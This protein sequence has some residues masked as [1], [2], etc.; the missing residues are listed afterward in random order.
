MFTHSTS[1]KHTNTKTQSLSHTH[2]PLTTAAAAAAAIGPYA[3]RGMAEGYKHGV[4]VDRSHIRPQATIHSSVSAD[5]TSAQT[6]AIR[7]KSNWWKVQN[8]K[9]NVSVI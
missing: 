1:G 4:I 8:T 9:P 6:P 5:L 2:V 7:S 3:V